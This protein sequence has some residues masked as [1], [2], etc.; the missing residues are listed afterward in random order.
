MVAWAT[1]AGYIGK[2]KTLGIVAGDRASDQLA[3]NEYLLPYL[4]KAGISHPVVETIAADPAD[5]ATTASEAP[6][7]VQRFRSAGVD[8]V[9]QMCIRDRTSPIRHGPSG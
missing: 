2:G 1:S 9:I 6:L 7:I 3:L 5:S 4:K 8:A